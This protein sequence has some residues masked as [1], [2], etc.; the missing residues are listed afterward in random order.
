[1]ART[2][3]GPFLL[4]SIGKNVFLGRKTIDMQIRKLGSVILPGSI[5]VLVV[6]LLS[7]SKSTYKGPDV[8]YRESDHTYRP[9]AIPDT[10][11]FAGLTVPVNRFDIRECLDREL[12]VNSYF[13]SQTIRFIKLAPRYFP[14]IEP[15]LKENGIPDDFKYLAVAE[16]N[17]DPKAISPAGAIGFWQFMRG[18]AIE[19]G[20]E[21]NGEVDERYHVEKSTRA[22]CKY[23]LKSYK[24]YG[25]WLLVAASYNS[26]NGHVETQ[27]NRQKRKS[28]FDLLLGEE[29]NR[30]VYRIIALKMVLEHPEKY[31]FKVDASEKYPLIETKLVEIPGPVP[32]LPDFAGS[33][34]LS[35][36]MLKIF[37]PWLR[38]I[39]LTNPNRKKYLVKLPV[40]INSVKPVE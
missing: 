15:I 33:Y 2:I 28:Y 24:K 18:T 34:G 11:N 8:V 31:G 30:Y 1:M 21:V 20:L 38:D 37:N 32:S 12:L 22:A 16:S 36:K 14:V 26:G 13:H 35:Y 3:P 40:D 4:K 6:I 5:V 39:K 25:N 7:L 10:L 17:M 29:T 9:V 27:M 19:Y 23:L